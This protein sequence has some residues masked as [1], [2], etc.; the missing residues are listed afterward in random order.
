MKLSGFLLTYNLYLLP[1]YTLIPS[2]LHR[3]CKTKFSIWAPEPCLTQ[4]FRDL[5]LLGFLSLISYTS[6][7]HT[8]PYSSQPINI[9]KY[10]P[11]LKETLPF[12]LEPPLVSL[13]CP[14]LSPFLFTHRCQKWIS[15]FTA[16]IT[17]HS[18]F[19]HCNKVF[20]YTSSWKPHLLRT[21]FT[22]KLLFLMGTF[23]PLSYWILLPH[24]IVLITSVCLKF[25]AQLTF[26][27][28]FSLFFSLLFR[29][30]IC[31][32]FMDSYSST[33]LLNIYIFQWLCPWPISTLYYLYMD[34]FQTY[35]DSSDL[36]PDM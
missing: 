12:I 16:F 13:K 36:P 6:H 26:R 33:Y 21:P 5:A 3:L 22:D 30:Y 4:P 18:P 9:L 19:N 2:P 20:T 7:P 24:I 11:S 29:F 10:F 34:D 14:L 15:T 32:T 27:H 17:S 28:T 1:Y 23:K 35:V 31:A 8:L 25:S